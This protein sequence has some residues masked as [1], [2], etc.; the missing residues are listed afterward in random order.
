MGLFAKTDVGD[1]EQGWANLS[2]R[3]EYKFLRAPETGLVMIRGRAGGT[4]QAFNMGETT[5]TRCAVKLANG[6]TGHA[7][8]AG[9]NRRHA[10]L[11]AVF[12]GL[13]QCKDYRLMLDG[14]LL[15]PIERKLVS[16]RQ[17][18]AAKT[19]ATKVDFFTLVRGEDEC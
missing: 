18:A 2:D 11:A 17:Q 16:R 4:G 9:R 8:V 7:Y 10:E 15:A 14:A 5:V 1:L 12:D 6:S 19:A 13:M 3:P